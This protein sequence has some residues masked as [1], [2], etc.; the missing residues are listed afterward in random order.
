[1]TGLIGI[2]GLWR[3]D[4]RA[5]E[6]DFLPVSVGIVWGGEMEWGEVAL[7]W[8]RHSDGAHKPCEAEETTLDG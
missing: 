4:I 7:L 6:S 2:R 1:M 8:D 5:A 3:A